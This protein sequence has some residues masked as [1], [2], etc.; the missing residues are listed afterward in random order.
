MLFSDI[1]NSLSSYEN[2]Y[3]AP[4]PDDWLQGRSC[5]GGLQTAL[6]VAA[7]RKVLPEAPPLRCVQTT[8][9][10]PVPA[11]FVAIEARILRTGRS[12][13]H[14]EARLYD[15]DQL[16]CLVIAVFGVA[17]SSIVT[18]EHPPLMIEKSAEQ[19]RELPYVPGIAPAFIQHMRFRWAEGGFPFSGSAEAMTRVYVEVR[20]EPMITESHVIALADSIPTPALSLFNKPTPASSLTWMLEFLSDDLNT[21]TAPWLM[22][23]QVTAGHSG[24]LSQTATLWSA[25]RKAICLSRQSVVVFG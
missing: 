11:G 4:I 14:V 24:Y 8:F 13:T 12:A 7:M 5:F 10:A 9:L 15:G 25:E 17:R 20:N 22:D 1:I 3:R 19:S 6:A 21:P 16:A 23:A 2:G 18:I